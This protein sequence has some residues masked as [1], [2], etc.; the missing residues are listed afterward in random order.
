MKLLSELN[1]WVVAILQWLPGSTGRKLRA[2]Y[3]KS[4]FKAAGSG[5]SIG[6]H[7][8]I[9]SPENIELGNNV[10]LMDSCYLVANEGRIKIGNDFCI[11]HNS[12]INAADGGAILIGDE[13][14]IAQNV[15]IRA[16]DHRFSDLDTP[17][18]RQGHNPGVIV[19]GDNVWIGANVVVTRNTNIRTGSIVGAGA[20]VTHDV[21]EE[22]IVA[23][24]PARKIAN[25]L[26]KETPSH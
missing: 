20:V 6:R 22:T 5:L 8:A 16:S 24:V 11:N 9:H 26:D 19:I 17:I 10:R 14:L 15:V 21:N 7:V 25:R 13:V 2:A 12:S 3:Y 23:G 18:L 4:K 1:A